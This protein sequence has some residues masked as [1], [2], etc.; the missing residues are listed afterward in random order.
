[1]AAYNNLDSLYK[2]LGKQIEKS[3]DKTAD[4]LVGKAKNLI[5]TRFYALYDPKEYTRT[6]QMLDSVVRSRI[7]KIPN[8]YSVE[9]YLDPTGVTYESI[10][11]WSSFLLASEGYHGSKEIETK[12]KF[13]DE[14]VKETMSEWRD[15]LVKSGL[16]VMI[17]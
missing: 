10:D 2:A 11:A 13:W 6:F 8:G 5:M 12:G 4:E 7:K 9:I 3:L 15:L 14:F 17:I 1:M 16:D